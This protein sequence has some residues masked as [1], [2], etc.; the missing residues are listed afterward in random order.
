MQIKFKYILIIIA[1]ILF[2]SSGVIWYISHL[3]DIIKDKESTIIIQRQNAAALKDFIS[4]QADSLQD[5][6][7]FVTDLQKNNTNIK[8][9]YTLLKSKYIILIDSIKVLNAHADVDTTGNTIVVKFKGRQGK[10]SYEGHTTYFKLSGKGTYSI[11]IGVDSSNV[12][13]Q[14]Y[15]DI[16]D[17][18]IKNRIY[19]DGALIKNAK[20][21]ID[22][23][24]ALRI[25]N[26]ELR[27]PEEPG[28][29]DRLHLLFDINQSIKRDGV[30]Y[31]PD[32]FSMGV[33]AEFQFDTFRIFGKYD[34]INSEINAGIQ[35]QPSLKQIWRN[36][37]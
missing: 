19:I 20:T 2:F 29:F 23:S 7:V 16:K 24:L 15:L 37:F 21:E 4:M 27:C 12:E 1:I 22:S 9:Q 26:S 18:L 6:A 31:T 3:N 13:S 14:I 25:Q 32:K 10:V 30:I 36:I 5:F 34:Y 17:N 33:G 28:F 8:N 11:I 35:Y